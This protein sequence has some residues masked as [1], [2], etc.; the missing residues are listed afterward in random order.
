MVALLRS[1]SPLTRRDN[2]QADLTLLSSRWVIGTTLY[3]LLPNVIA[4]S[5]GS[6]V[7]VDHDMPDRQDLVHLSPWLAGLLVSTCPRNRKQDP[8][9]QK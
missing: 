6:V 4:T 2:D 7:L 8:V 1:M 3:R 9:S 5:G